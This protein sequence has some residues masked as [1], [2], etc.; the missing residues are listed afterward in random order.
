MVAYEETLIICSSRANI[1]ER[2]LEHLIV[3]VAELLLF[4]LSAKPGLL[5]QHEGHGRENLESYRQEL[6]H[7]EGYT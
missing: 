2:Q 7:L 3:I 4:D 1:M 6:R 5:C